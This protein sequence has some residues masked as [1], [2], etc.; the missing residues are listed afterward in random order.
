M[1]AMLITLF[2]VVLLS[3]LTLWLAKH[4]L[5][6]SVHLPPQPSVLRVIDV[7]SFKNL[8]FPRR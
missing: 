8:I 2:A 5:S 1:T 7:S 6:A 3:A 4:A